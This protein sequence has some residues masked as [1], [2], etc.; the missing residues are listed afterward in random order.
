MLLLLPLLCPFLIAPAQEPTPMGTLSPGAIETHTI[1][2]GGM[3]VWEI[4]AEADCRVEGRLLQLEG[5]ASLVVINP[6]NQELPT[7]DFSVEGREPFRFHKTQEGR[8]RL[9]I[10]ATGD[11]PHRL[12]YELYL[13]LCE[14]V[15][16]GFDARAEQWL[17]TASPREP[18]VAVWTIREG[19]PIGLHFTGSSLSD[20]RRALRVDD[21]LPMG[22]IE[23]DLARLGVLHLIASKRLRRDTSLVDAAALPRFH[24]S[25]TVAQLLRGTAGLRNLEL[26][27][28]LRLAEIST[29]RLLP[30]RFD[31]LAVLQRESVVPPGSNQGS[32]PSRVQTIYLQRVCE[33]VTG[34]RYF[35]WITRELFGKLAMRDSWLI[36]RDYEGDPIFTRVEWEDR[37]WVRADRLDPRAW[38]APMVSLRDLTTWLEFLRSEALLARMWREEF[39]FEYADFAFPNAGSVR[40]SLRTTEQPEKR[41]Y[42]E[43]DLGS[44][45]GGPGWRMLDAALQGAPL[46]LKHPDREMGI[47]GRGK[48]GIPALPKTPVRAG[49]SG[50]Y[51]APEVYLTIKL[52]R[53]EDGHILL[54][55]PLRE[56]P[57]SFYQSDEA[58]RAVSRWVLIRSIRFFEDAQGRV[59]GFRASGNGLGNILFERVD[60]E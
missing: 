59:I 33:T 56:K 27:E 21:A 29:Q 25:A 31:A 4:E 54:V 60:S 13:G 38:H 6:D 3:H 43:L 52:V 42:V 19:Q 30:D 15:A 16:S 28:R 23:L 1:E 5:D 26:V 17:R 24:P 37:E 40:L 32:L 2:A 7:F 45:E 14:P 18:A 12:R 22:E 11:T 58:D 48:R 8:Y 53:G 46:Q 57:L 49:V 47:G 44:L 34:E 20:P 36:P 41:A 51:F 9:A 35:E 55:H 50:A 10:F 39:G